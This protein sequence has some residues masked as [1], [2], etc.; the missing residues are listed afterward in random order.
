MINNSGLFLEDLFLS[1]LK[2]IFF[3]FG[4]DQLFLYSLTNS[5]HS[6]GI[7]KLFLAYV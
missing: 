2:F 4:A 7:M 5:E 6:G 1:S 3:L